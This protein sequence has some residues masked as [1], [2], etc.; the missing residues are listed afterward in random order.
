MDVLLAA[1]ATHGRALSRGDLTRI[2]ANSDKQRFEWDR[3]A[4]GSAPGRATRS[5]STS[6]RIR[7]STPTPS[8]PAEAPS[9]CSGSTRS[10]THRDGHVFRC[11]TNGVWLVDVVAPAYLSLGD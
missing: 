7:T 2:V 10:A 4:T 11:S 9:S 8:G 6:R 5:T 3:Q 1:L